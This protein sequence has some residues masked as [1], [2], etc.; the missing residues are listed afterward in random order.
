MK[1]YPTPPTVAEVVAKLLELPQD[2]PMYA[3][4]KYC[5]RIEPYED[6]P[7]HLN[8]IGEMHPA[9]KPKNVTFLL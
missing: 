6:V 7:V 4:P 3:R 5:G 8:G 1:A 9:E 2:L